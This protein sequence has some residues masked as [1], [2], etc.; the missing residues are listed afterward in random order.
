M[1]NI[2]ILTVN[3]KAKEN[4]YFFYLTNS[5]M[6]P[7]GRKSSVAMKHKPLKSRQGSIIF[8]S[9]ISTDKMKE[10]TNNSSD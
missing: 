2:V 3:T 4:K 10:K 7:H 6:P 9:T 8:A 5:L 1:L